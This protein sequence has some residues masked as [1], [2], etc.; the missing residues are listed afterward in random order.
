MQIW[1]D[2]TPQLKLARRLLQS[3]IA[4]FFQKPI[5]LFLDVDKPY[6]VAIFE[7]EELAQAIGINGSNI[8]LTTNVTGYQIDAVSRSDYEKTQEIDINEIEDINAKFKKILIDNDIKTSS[9]FLTKEN[10]ELLSI[11]GLGPVS[12]EKIKEAI[13]SKIE[14]N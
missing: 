5:N 2:L 10:D 1:M 14:I 12:I 13:K 9:D 6:A 3:Q 11:K 8:K 4:G 7:D